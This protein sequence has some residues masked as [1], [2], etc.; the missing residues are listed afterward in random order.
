MIKLMELLSVIFMFLVTS[1]DLLSLSS[2]DTLYVTPNKTASCSDVEVSCLVLQEYTSQSDTYFT[3]DTIVC[4][5]PGIHTLNSSLKLTNVHD[6]AF[7]GLPGNESV[8]ILLGSLVSITWEKCSNIEISSITFTL[9]D[10]F[11]FSITFEET[12]LV[13]L[14]NISVSGNGNIGNSSIMGRNSTVGIRDSSFVG[15]HGRL[16]A[17]LMILGSCV[18]FAGNNTFLDNLA[19]YGGSMYISES[20]VTLEWNYITFS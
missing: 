3:N 11:T 7:R 2:S 18:T 12:H 10:K 8:N 13:Q 4:F 19:P 16:G 17:A 20:V 9:L 6:F 14:S 1:S 5:E 15:I